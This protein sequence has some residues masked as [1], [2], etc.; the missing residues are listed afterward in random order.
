MKGTCANCN[1]PCGVLWGTI[2]VCCHRR[3]HS[4]SAKPSHF[5]NQQ[6]NLIIG[7]M[8]G[9]GHLRKIN[10]NDNASLT[11]TR[12]TSDRAYLEWEAN[13]FDGLWTKRCITDY[14]TWDERTDETYSS[15][16]FVSRTLIALNQF[17]ARWY[18]RINDKFVKIIPNDLELNA[19]IIAVWFCDDGHILMGSPTRFNILFSTNGF[20][21]D[22]VYFLKDLLVN[23]YNEH[24]SV[25]VK[26]EEEYYI[27][28]ADASAR[29]I[30][31]DIDPVFPQGMQRKRLW[32]DPTTCFYANQPLKMKS[33]NVSFAEKMTQV[34]EYLKTHD[35]FYM[36]EL[37]NFAGFSMSKTTSAGYQSIDSRGLKNVYLS[38]FLNQGLMI[39][40]GRAK[41]G[42]EYALGI[43]MRLTDLGKQYF[44]SPSS[45]HEL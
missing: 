9:D 45:N 28:C 38:K 16:Q 11:I 41:S 24:F 15:S 34:K 3:I 35:E 32:D 39:D 23:R 8:L 27:C 43:K 20:T 4:A 12:A 19:E 31:S 10:K 22:E 33:H 25:N 13:I 7:S 29:A 6:T 26:N 17:H 36:V 40:L 42:P 44:Q 18:R 1:E 21:K 5:T 14:S 2:C 30:I 37:A